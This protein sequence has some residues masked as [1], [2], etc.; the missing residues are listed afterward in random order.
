MI[1]NSGIRITLTRT[2]RQHDADIIL[3][4]HQVDWTQIIPPFE[5][6]YR[7]QTYCVSQC[8]DHGLGNLK[9]IKVFGVLHHAHLLGRTIKTRHF[10]NG[11]ELP[12]LTTDSNYDFN[13]Q[14]TRL[15]REEIPIQHGDNFIVECTY[16]STGRSVPTVGGLSTQNEMCASFILYYPKIELK[17]CGSSPTYDSISNDLHKVRPLLEAYNWTSPQVREV[18][19]EKLR[20]SSITHSCEVDKMVP[21]FLKYTYRETPPTH[22]YIPSVSSTCP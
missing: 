21:R 15:L 1:D 14:E 10:R 11:T 20:G 8:I 7:S 3:I 2:I 5:K 18:F 12:P 13:F 22:E 16:D 19:E 4:S 6:A 17:S 9:E